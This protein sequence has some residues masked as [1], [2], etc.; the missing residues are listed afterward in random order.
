M[1]TSIHVVKFGSGLL[2]QDNSVKNSIGQHAKHLLQRHKN[3][4][5]IIVSSGAVAIGKQIAKELGYVE[6]SL[7]AEQLA[8]MGFAPVFQAWQEAFASHGVAVA[9]TGITHHQLGGGRWFHQLSNLSEKQALVRILRENVAAGI[10]TVLNESDMISNTELMRLVTGGDNDGLATRVAIA[11]GAKALTIYSEYGGVFDT[12]Q[13]LIETVN[14]HNINGLRSVLVERARSAGGRGG[15][16][17]KV[18]AAWAAA[19]AGVDYVA[20]TDVKGNNITRFVVG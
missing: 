20:I 10:V 12:N 3:S 14:S 6:N 18:E 1:N 17:A 2:T 7:S 13:K 19:K 11:V 15:V 4:G 8:G 9:S 16:Y 5:L